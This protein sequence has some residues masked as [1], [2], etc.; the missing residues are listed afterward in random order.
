[1]NSALVDR[2]KSVITSQELDTLV[3]YSADGTRK[4]D[5]VNGTADDL[6][7]AVELM[8]QSFPHQYKLEG[9]REAK[10]GQPG[11]RKDAD[12]PF[13]WIMP[14]CRPNAAPVAEQ[15]GA[16]VVREVKVPVPD[17][18][19]IRQAAT[20]EAKAAISEYKEQQ[21]RE[22]LDTLRADLNA[23]PEVIEEGDEE[24]EDEPI[25]SAW[26]HDADKTVET[27][28]RL[29]GIVKG[30]LMPTLKGPA[31][32]PVAT[33]EGVSEDERVLLE[34][35]RKFKANEPDTFMDL[36]SQLS[37]LYGSEQQ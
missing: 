23:E 17:V 26:Y 20:A 14:G 5:M 18:E 22:Q 8:E 12:K 30:L 13:V 7:A 28:E 4:L 29:A 25:G 31:P 37:N 10:A 19:A 15:M 34:Q 6:H 21:L 32:A 24:D 1:M 11:R 27:V 36:R 16:P 35:I 3:A 33:T 9:Y 2:I